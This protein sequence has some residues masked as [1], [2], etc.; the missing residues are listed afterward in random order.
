MY[1][2]AS[3]L[4]SGFPPLPA[5]HVVIPYPTPKGKRKPNPHPLISAAIQVGYNHIN[6]CRQKRDT[7]SSFRKGPQQ[8][9][10]QTNSH[11]A[12]VKSSRPHVACTQASGYD[13]HGYNPVA[14]LTSS[15]YIFY[16]Q[17]ELSPPT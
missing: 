16:P 1:L 15:P 3:Y 6:F 9:K 2:L 8:K 17:R 7:G 4:L 12:Q 14:T 13:R 5:Y 10:T 11:K